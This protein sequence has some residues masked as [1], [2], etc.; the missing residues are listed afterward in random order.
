MTGCLGAELAALADGTIVPRRRERAL[1]HVARCDTCRRALDDQ[2]RVRAALALSPSPAPTIDLN[3]RLLAVAWL[4]AFDA[5]PATGPA[6]V[7][8]PAPPGGRVTSASPRP[9]PGAGRLVVVGG[10]ASLMTLAGLT[11]LASAPT[12]ATQVPAL[13]SPATAAVAS[14]TPARKLRRCRRHPVHG[15]GVPADG[16]HPAAGAGACRGGTAAPGPAGGRRQ[17]R[18]RPAGGTTDRSG[19]GISAAVTVLLRRGARDGA[20]ETVR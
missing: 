11:I 20:V 10:T 4:E 18:F 9:G 7:T 5:A 13:R 12:A 2:R 19:A 16:G 8:V 15:R 14:G 17:R 3:A 6:P 1:A